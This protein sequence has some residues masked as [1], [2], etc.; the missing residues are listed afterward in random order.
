[1][2]LD[3]K[4]AVDVMKKATGVN[5]V[6]QSVFAVPHGFVGM[7]QSKEEIVCVTDGPC[8]FADRLV[9]IKDE[10]RYGVRIR[11]AQMDEK[12]SHVLR[13]FIKWTAP[14]ACQNKVSSIGLEDEFGLVLPVLAQKLQKEDIKPVLVSG[15]DSI[16][17]L[18]QSLSKVAWQ[19]LSGGLVNGYGAEYP[20]VKDESTVMNVLLAGHTGMV[21][22]CSDKV[23]LSAFSMSEEEISKEFSELPEEFREALLTSY[24][25][26]EIS[27]KD[28]TSINY[29]L[30]T[31]RRIAICYGE[32]IAYLQYIYN[33]YFKGAPWP[34]DF[35]VYL[36][37]KSLFD[38]AQ[39]LLVNELIRSGVKL[40]S[41]QL[42]EINL[43]N[44]LVANE[45]E[46]KLHV[47][48]SNK[49]I[50]RL[51]KLKGQSKC[52][53]DIRP[54]VG[55]G[56]LDVATI[57]LQKDVLATVFLEHEEKLIRQSLVSGEISQEVLAILQGKK[58]ELA[59]AVLKYSIEYKEVLEDFIDKQ[60]AL[61]I[62]FA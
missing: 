30:P 3:R 13:L 23:N 40:T 21:I 25:D 19:A 10:Y 57:L 58:E 51:S 36:G 54:V 59:A 55:Q 43:E 60:K 29:D 17:N 61:L 35:T 32:A 14:S 26:K 49:Q 56:L 6:E 20:Y 41:L 37:E 11:I 27:F 8:V 33:A 12:N 2:S 62:E 39:Y 48:L 45:L 18:A 34:V 24:V 50:D 4:K 9:C 31:L 1:M 16:V 47:I 46:H 42:E 28:G 22:D 53:L 15:A 38:K 44:M 5:V 7:L 52:L